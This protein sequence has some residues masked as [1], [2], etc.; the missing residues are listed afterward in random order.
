MAVAWDIPVRIVLGW[1]LIELV[2]T[3]KAHSNAQVV[4]SVS[5][6]AS[7]TTV[8]KWLFT[9]NEQA[10][11]K[12]V[13]VRA[14]G[15]IKCNCISKHSKICTTQT[16]EKQPNSLFVVKVHIDDKTRVLDSHRPEDLKSL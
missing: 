8:W 9:P 11:R 3:W 16:P 12:V 7:N 13:Q 14:V 10:K 5:R 4:S 6:T 15:C 2:N 1:P